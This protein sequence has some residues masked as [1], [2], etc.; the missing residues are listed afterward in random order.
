MITKNGTASEAPQVMALKA[1]AFLAG[2]EE[3]LDGFLAS[4]GIDLQDLKELAGDE[5][6]LAGLLDH[7]LQN[8]NLLLE[9]SHSIDCKPEMIVKARHALPGAN[10]DT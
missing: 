10:H 4:S 3:Y 7:V 8:E 9:F 5:N 1:L 6:M 2:N